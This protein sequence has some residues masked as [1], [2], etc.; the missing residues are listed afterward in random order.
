MNASAGKN[1]ILWLA[2][3]ILIL[4]CVP[5]TPT[6]V[7]TLNPSDINLFIQQTADAATI[8]TLTAVPTFTP[9]ATATSTPRNT[10]TPEPTQTPFVTFV[11]PSPTIP[12]SLHYYRVKHDS[13]LA[14]YNFRSR[15]KMPDWGLNPQ[16]PEVVPLFLDAKQSSGTGRTVVDGPWE[17]YINALN[18]FDNAKLR[19]LKANNSALFNRAGFP[20]L[21]SLTM[22]GNVITLEQ[23]RG[24]WGR[25]HTMSISQ[26]GS[27]ET[28]NYRTRPDLVHKFV[29]VVWNQERKTTYWVNPPKGDTYWPLVSNRPV[30]IQMDRVEPF[31]YLPMP[32]TAAVEQQ[33]RRE[34]GTDGESTGQI[35]AVGESVT[36]TQYKL[37]ASQVWGR[38]QNGRWIALFLYQNTG[39]TYFTSWSMETL[40]PPP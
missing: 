26:V 7:P 36:I 5:A 40:P 21:E 34:P 2:A 25:V 11:L 39:P 32:V 6:P 1:T 38:L 9:T 19:Y 15:T 12:F 8:Q 28:E 3:L 13:Q 20:Q 23:I 14:I 18:G 27:A 17:Q 30:W 4:A 10:F 31:P 29:V 16:T 37:I 33:I 24:G 22:G 35:L